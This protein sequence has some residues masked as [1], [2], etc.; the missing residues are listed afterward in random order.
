MAAYHPATRKRAL[1]RSGVPG[2]A[3]NSHAPHMPLLL[4][5]LPHPQ[6]VISYS[7]HFDV[8]DSKKDQSECGCLYKQPFVINSISMKSSACHTFLNPLS[9]RNVLFALSACARPG[10][11]SCRSG[12]SRLSSDE[13]PL[14]RHETS[15]YPIGS[16]FNPPFRRNE[17]AKVPA[18]TLKTVA[19]IGYAVRRYLRALL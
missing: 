12:D 18:D 19:K 13:T 3:G 1:G 17:L 6:P 2:G 5:S 4:R 11:S 10:R 14:L 8:F 9:P 15:Q 16:H 7:F